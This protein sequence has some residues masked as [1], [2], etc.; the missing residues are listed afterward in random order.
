MDDNVTIFQKSSNFL[1]ELPYLNMGA[2][3]LVGLAV[4]YVVKKSFKIM[5]FILGL[6][7]ILVF[8]LEYKNIVII[9]ENE[10]MGMV[11]TIQSSFSN[12]VI[13]L[14]NRLAKMKIY[15]TLSAITGFIVGIKMG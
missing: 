2:S 12:F 13:L 15:G 1:A 6:S 9:N 5:L 14:K 8:F 10:L 7:I 3:F 11:D 4:G